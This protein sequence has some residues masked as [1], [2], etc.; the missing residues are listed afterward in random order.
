MN[1]YITDEQGKWL[2][3][4]NARL[5]IEPSESYLAQRELERIQQEEEELLDSLIP[6]DKEL[7]M[8][9]VEIQT[10]TILMEVG[11]I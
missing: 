10:I 11:L 7:L 9:E 2:I 8:A 3:Q 4:G 1:E 5:L 6:S